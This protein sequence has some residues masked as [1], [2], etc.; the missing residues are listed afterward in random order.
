MEDMLDDVNAYEQKIHE[1]V[2]QCM[3]LLLSGQPLGAPASW[4][5]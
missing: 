1:G 3:Q 4:F 2:R 5:A